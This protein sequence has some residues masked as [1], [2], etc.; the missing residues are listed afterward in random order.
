MS[1]EIFI[2]LTIVC[3]S[4]VFVWLKMWRW[5]K[6]KKEGGR[7]NGGSSSL[8]V[9]TKCTLRITPCHLVGVFLYIDYHH[10]I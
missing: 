6:K 3:C 7:G 10:S 2:I 8:G 5:E 1:H 4:L 9:V